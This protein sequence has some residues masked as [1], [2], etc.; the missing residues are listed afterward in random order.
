VIGENFDEFEGKVC[1]D[2]GG[3]RARQNSG[4]EKETGCN[5]AN[6]RWSKKVKTGKGKLLSLKAAGV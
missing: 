3:R 2:R 6:L 1:Q 4:I 5:Q